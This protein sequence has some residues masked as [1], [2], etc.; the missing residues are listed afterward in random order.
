MLISDWSS[1]VCSSDLVLYPGGDGDPEI[2]RDRTRS[3]RRAVPVAV[4]HRSYPDRHLEPDVQSHDSRSARQRDR[5]SA[6]SG[7]SVSVRVDHGGRSN[8]KKKRYTKHIIPVAH[9]HTNT[10]QNQ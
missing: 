10:K 1:D 2:P 6:V 3:D 4:V 5:K 9:E 8:I 7:K